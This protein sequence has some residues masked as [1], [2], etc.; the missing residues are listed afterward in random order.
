MHLNDRTA[1]GDVLT[2]HYLGRFVAGLTLKRHMQ[3]A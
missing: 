2:V 1:V 3:H